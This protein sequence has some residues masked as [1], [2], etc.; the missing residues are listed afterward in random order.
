MKLAIVGAGAVGLL[1]GGRLRQAG[2]DVRFVTRRRAQARRL[3]GEGVQIED[4]S[5]GACATLAADAIAIEQAD[6]VSMQGRLL[7]LCVRAAHTRA[8]GRESTPW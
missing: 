2:C 3:C 5:S 4:P 6:A 1:L 8:S 7:V